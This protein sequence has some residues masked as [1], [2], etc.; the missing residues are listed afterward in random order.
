M[1]SAVFANTLRGTNFTGRIIDKAGFLRGY[2][3]DGKNKAVAVCFT[4]AAPEETKEFIFIPGNTTDVFGNPT[5]GIAVSSLP[6]YVSAENREKLSAVLKNYGSCD[7]NTHRPEGLK[8]A[9]RANRVT[10]GINVS[11][12]SGKVRLAP[13]KSSR[14]TV[15]TINA[16]WLKK[17]SIYMV[18]IQRPPILNDN[19]KYVSFEFTAQTSGKVSVILRGGFAVKAE[20][21]EPAL[22]ANVI[23]NGKPVEFRTSGKA[24][25]IPGGGP[26]GKG[27]AYLVNHDNG[28]SYILPVEAGKNYLIEA[29]VK[30]GIELKNK[31]ETPIEKDKKMNL[32]KMSAVTL[33]AASTLIGAQEVA[34][35][36]FAGADGVK[37]WGQTKKVEVI[38]EEK[39]LTLIHKG[40]DS[41][42]YRTISLEP[43]DYVVTTNGMDVGIQIQRDWTPKSIV[44]RDELT[45]EKT[46]SAKELKLDEGGKLHLCVTAP[47]KGSII[48]LKISKIKK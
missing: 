37:G 28:A 48:S 12:V 43:G 36:Q 31:M 3:F 26:D 34:N 27:S 6:T 22:F 10:C 2:L 44:F 33:I 32:K 39:S 16:S 38:P 15:K 30:S 20:D 23:I 9:K 21:R 17:D 1:V 8:I 24:R 35:F 29:E 46:T 25:E 47:K 45:G 40:I 13:P 7:W 5:P 11:G 4:P 41:K 14:G 42:I 18:T 19:W